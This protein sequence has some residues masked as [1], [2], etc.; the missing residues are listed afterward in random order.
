MVSV[1]LRV[2]VCV[3]VCMR[4]YVCVCVCV[5]VCVFVFMCV[6]VRSEETRLAVSTLPLVLLVSHMS[7][8]R[9]AV[10]SLSFAIAQ[11]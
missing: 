4:V 9:S 6:Y 3:R 2:C 10:S 7:T 5:C 1:V 8:P 11:Q